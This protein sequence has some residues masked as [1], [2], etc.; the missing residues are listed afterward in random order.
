[1]WLSTQHKAGE[2]HVPKE[3]RKEG[4]KEGSG[5]LVREFAELGGLAGG[6]GSIER[7]REAPLALRAARGASE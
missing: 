6:R 5:G 4:R 7:T 3:G 2:V 1:M